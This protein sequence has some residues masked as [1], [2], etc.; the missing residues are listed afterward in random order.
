MSID[1][2]LYETYLQ[3]M[4]EEMIPATGCTEPIAIA[5]A[6]ARAREVLGALPDSVD[7]KVSI[8]IFKNARSVTVPN[9]GGLKGI[10]TAAA[11]GIT[12]G[13]AE[14]KLEVLS[15]MT[16]SDVS[17]VEAFMTACPITIDRLE[18]DLDFDILIT[19]RKG[20]DTAKVRVAFYH[21][22]IVHEEKNGHVFLDVPVQTSGGSSDRSLLTMEGICEFAD[23][24]VL[25][26]VKDL[27]ALQ[28]RYNM[29]IAE[30][31]LRGDYGA[32]I[33]STLLKTDDTLKTKAKAMAAAG[34]DARMAG[35][36]MPV[37]INSGSGNQGITLSVPVIVYAREIGVSEEKLYRSLVL[38]NLTTIRLRTPLGRLSAYCGAIS[39][40]AA[41]GAGIA[42]LYGG[43]YKDV[44]HTIVNALAIVSGVICDGA[45]SSCAAKIASGVDAGIFGYQMYLNG[46]QFYGGDG[47]VVKG[48]ENTIENVGELGRIGMVGTNEE[49]VKLMLQ[50]C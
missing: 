20:S 29:A 30:E 8:G 11:A 17:R 22:N 18:T 16:D 42:Y 21:T 25:D 50:D 33:G 26:D 49:I 15:A 24:V 6:A 45:K 14:K 39:A 44:I 13:K 19:L 7:V 4:K 32:N 48:V 12:A 47:I 41:A 23:T 37:V 43:G 5:F 1:K 38:A 35:L 9:T 34:S 2:K 46:Q 31:G 40:G 27:I 28:I 36:K 3:I 10:G